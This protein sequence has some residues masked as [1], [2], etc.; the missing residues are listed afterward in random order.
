MRIEIAF[1]RSAVARRVFWV[2]LAAAA[3][4]LLV[5]AGLAY[6]TLA[7]RLEAHLNS[8]LHEAAK[9]SGL[10]VYDRLIAAQMGLSA[11][12]AAD[13][14]NEARR[15]IPSAVHA[16][17]QGVVRIA[18]AGGKVDGPQEL[19]DLWRQL[20]ADRSRAIDPARRRMWWQ[21]TRGGESRVL[22]G[23]RTDHAWWIAEV[24]PGF[25]WGEL[26]DADAF[27]S[28]CVTDVYGR[29]LMCPQNMQRIDAAADERAGLRS[30]T[31]NLFTRADFSTV[32][33]VFTRRSSRAQ[34]FT[35]E[36]PLEDVAWKAAVF[37]LLLVTGLSLVL[38]RRTTVPLERLIDGTRRLA[39]R[40]WSARVQVDATDEFG[41]LAG[42]FNQM[43]GR[44]ERQVQAMQVQ[45]GIDHEILSGMDLP[46]VLAQVAE[47]LQA[48]APTARVALLLAPDSAGRWQRM[49]PGLATAD[50]VA[51]DPDLLGRL[52]GDP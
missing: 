6:G 38:V 4:P 9:Y 30:V 51:V 2:V 26:R 21:A 14:Q 15:Q 7:E 43:A 49:A 29:A 35:G 39:G 3:L 48:L 17:F 12:A 19:A 8:R 44:I 46:R 11:V 18:D 13:D 42:S 25:L 50:A 27:V 23:V 5:F 32:D 28:T 45:A 24:A 22:L 47:R 36:L 10:R 1:L 31:W 52:E 37:S 40:D 34:L 20:D 41:E 33:W 16:V